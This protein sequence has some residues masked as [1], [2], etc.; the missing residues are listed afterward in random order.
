MLRIFFLL[1]NIRRKGD[2]EI[3]KTAT[4]GEVLLKNLL[5]ISFS[6]RKISCN[7]TSAPPSKLFAV[8]I[9]EHTK[10]IIIRFSNDFVRSAISTMQV[11]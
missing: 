9:I 8:F 3:L 10:E 11:W 6:E 5:V 2:H 7:R 1:G 4:Y